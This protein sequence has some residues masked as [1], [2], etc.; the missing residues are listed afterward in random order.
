MS[1]WEIIIT[2]QTIKRALG[3]LANRI[4]KDYQDKQLILISVL[5]GAI[6]F[7]VDLSRH[8]DINHSI[9]FIKVSSYGSGEISSKSEIT[10]LVNKNKISDKHVLIVDELYDSGHTL[11]VVTNFI[12]ELNPLSIKTC[13]MFRKDKESKYNQPDY[14]GIDNIPDRWLI[15][16]G[17]DDNGTK[18]NLEDLYAK[19]I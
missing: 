8:L 11:E 18:R 16:Y 10:C 9:D 15:G 13:V 19:V 2:K 5:S 7:T 4:D 12:K 17:L 6:Y 3:S 1:N 14:C